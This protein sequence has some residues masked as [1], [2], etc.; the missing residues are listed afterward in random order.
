MGWRIRSNLYSWE[1]LVKAKT[2]R[3]LMEYFIPDEYEVE[4]DGFYLTGLK[5]DLVPFNG[6]TYKVEYSI[7]VSEEQEI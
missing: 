6:K 4:E 7:S 3:L 5:V 2:L 1:K